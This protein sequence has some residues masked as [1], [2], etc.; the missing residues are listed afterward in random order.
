MNK[1][2]KRV[3]FCS[4]CL[5]APLAQAEPKPLSL[6]QLFER[7]LAHNPAVERGFWQQQAAQGKLEESR[8]AFQ[9]S[10]RLKSELSY[11]WM[12]RDQFART[13]N[14]LMVT[15]PLYD[16]E[17]QS[18]RKASEYRLAS[19]EAMLEATRQQ[20]LLQVASHYYQYWQSRAE[21]DFLQKERRF[22]L[23]MLDQSEQRLRVGYQDLH[24]VA[25]IQARLDQNRAALMQ[26][27]ELSERRLHALNEQ[28][29]GERLVSVLAKP[30]S[31]E[32]GLASKLLGSAGGSPAEP[33][34]IREIVWGKVVED[35]PLLRA[36]QR[37][38]QA[39]QQQ[40][41]LQRNRDGLKIEA[42]GALAYNESDQHYYDDMRGTRG[43]V[44]LEV[45]LY[46]GGR[47]DSRVAQARS[48]S[49]QVRA[50]IRQQ[51]LKLQKIAQNAWLGVD[52]GQNRLAALVEAE[53]S[54]LRAVEATEQAIRSG[55]RDVLDLLN[56]QR[57]WYKTQRNLAAL[58]A[59]I[60]LQQ[61]A[62]YWATGQLT[63]DS[64]TN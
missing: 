54:N 59:E 7:A 17:L 3:A 18:D 44:R 61:V 19:E 63:A 20:T 60:G 26:A 34:E 57:D 32:K 55:G 16:A 12:E 58:K 38:W 2:I 23:A 21:S 33:A 50:R 37:K 29:G 39:S 22:L 1:L 53:R 62:F 13:A 15:Y 35:H 6:S 14:Q 4:F 5:L 51:S 42:F 45:P 11:A 31:V 28:L 25:E 36:W 41:S 27:E 30:P 46:L 40:I 10:V 52:S 24:D 48:R 43:G 56:A 9:P 64:L 49:E 47:T 8:S